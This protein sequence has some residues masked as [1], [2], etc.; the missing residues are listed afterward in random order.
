[1]TL[2]TSTLRTDTA[3][4]RLSSKMSHSDTKV[5]HSAY[6]Q[7]VGTAA[8]ATVPVAVAEWASME[9]Q[10]FGDGLECLRWGL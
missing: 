6:P 4:M 7:V 10:G 3:T 5:C 8:A 2:K 1:M 9:M